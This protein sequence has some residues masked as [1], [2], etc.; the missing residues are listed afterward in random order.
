MKLIPQSLSI[1]QVVLSKAKQQEVSKELGFGRAIHWARL[2]SEAHRVRQRGEQVW[3][4]KA[5]C[6]PGRCETFLLQH[7]C[8]EPPRRVLHRRKSL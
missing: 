7:R 3:M 2:G 4:V 1:R 6:R 8:W 5:L